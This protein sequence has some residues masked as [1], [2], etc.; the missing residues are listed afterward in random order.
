MF[1]FSDYA[2]TLLTFCFLFRK[3]VSLPSLL[4]KTYTVIQEDKDFE[5]LG[6]WG[7]CNK[8]SGVDHINIEDA[9]AGDAVEGAGF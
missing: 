4:C 7:A 3:K 5:I 6:A 2:S 8:N 1:R 9:K